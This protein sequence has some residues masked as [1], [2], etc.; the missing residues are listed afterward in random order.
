MVKRLI[1]HWQLYSRINN[2]NSD[3]LKDINWKE[4][5]KNNS[6]FIQNFD[7][8]KDMAVE[9][10]GDSPIITASYGSKSLRINATDFLPFFGTDF[11]FCSLVKPQ[12]NFFQEYDHLPFSQKM[13][14]PKKEKISFSRKIKRGVKVGKANGLKLLLDAE[15]FDYTFHK[16][17]SEGF[18]MAV[19]HHLDQPLMSVKELDIA[20]GFETQIAVSPLLYATTN[21]ALSRFTAE[22]R[23]CYSENEL[24]FRY[25]PKSL[26][27]YDISNCLFEATY[28]KVLEECK[29]TPYFHWAGVKEYRNFCRG[30]SL[31]CMNE[32]LSR[33]GEFNEV[34]D[35]LNMN[36]PQ[37][38]KRCLAACENQ[39]SIQCS[40]PLWA[41]FALF[42]RLTVAL[43]FFFMERFHH[44]A[45]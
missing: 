21:E 11:G 16:S 8:V 22:E 43:N 9:D 33:L 17:A 12:L 13:F 1:K 31:L 34:V 37:T 25:L 38:K 6:N 4:F 18:K 2:T 44:D 23:G 27:R 19:Q 42:T 40:D 35:N 29:C 15:T 32:I 24:T 3:S 26:Y 41:L 10:P 14:G 20:P 7:Y 30:P 5:L 36:A 28:Q 45:I 39:V